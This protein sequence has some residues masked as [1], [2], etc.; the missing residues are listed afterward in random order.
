MS[1]QRFEWGRIEWVMDS[2]KLK[3]PYPMSIGFLTLDAKQRQRKHIHYGEEQIL[4]IVQGQGLQ[5]I[6]DEE[7]YCEKGD[8]IY[9]EAGSAH[10]TVNTSEVPLIELVISVPSGK[11]VPSSFVQRIESLL[12][13]FE[14]TTID[15][16]DRLI[17]EKYRSSFSQLRFPLNL[18]DAKGEPVIIGGPYPAI[19]REK[20]GIHKDIRNC[21]LYSDAHRFTMAQRDPFGAV[22]CKYGLTVFV[23]PL[24]LSGKMVA[25]LQGGHVRTIESV[26]DPMLESMDR[27]HSGRIQAM[28]EQIQI[29]GQNLLN[30]TITK[31]LFSELD[32]SHASLK[33]SLDSQNHLEAMIRES[34]DRLYSVQLNNHFLFNTLNSLASMAVKEDA[35]QTYQGIID[36]ANLFRYNLRS[37]EKKRSS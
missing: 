21:Y 27:V 3:T 13:S 33:E 12:Q 34:E 19:C 9:I 30:D 4:Y 16:I 28:L 24:E 22:V 37:V 18:F 8:M 6:E 7:M 17:S 32:A 31:K 23:Y 15:N 10:E 25:L 2:H 14:G 35:F 29:I 1:I 26:G 5:I 20:C 36:L 11:V